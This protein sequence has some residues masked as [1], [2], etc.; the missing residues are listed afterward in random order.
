MSEEN[1]LYEI[2]FH[3]VSSIPEEKVGDEFSQLKKILE[4]HKAEIVKEGEVNLIDLAYEMVQKINGKNYK[5]DKSYFGWLHFNA[6]ADAIAEIKAELDANTNVLRYIIVKTTDD[7]G[8]STS[9]IALE[10][11]QEEGEG[12]KTE[13]KPKEEKTEE[14]PVKDKKLDEE[15]DEVIEEITEDSE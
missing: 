5:F 4:S 11:E 12:E 2:G 1:K 14:A 15:V 13:E 6:G 8:H 3:L 7:E 10:E 9:K